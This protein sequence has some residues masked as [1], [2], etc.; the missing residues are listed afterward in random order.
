MSD[1]RKPPLIRV[2][3]ILLYRSEVDPKFALPVRYELHAVTSVRRTKKG[4]RVGLVLYS[5]S[6]V[7][8]SSC[9]FP[10]GVVTDPYVLFELSQADLRTVWAE[11]GPLWKATSEVVSP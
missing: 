8:S 7:I 4:A 10:G 9:F 3:M 6:V 5:Q 1:R 2:G 11:L